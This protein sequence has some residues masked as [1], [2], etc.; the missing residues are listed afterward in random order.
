MSN[1]AHSKHNSQCSSCSSF[2]LRKQNE[3]IAWSNNSNLENQQ[4]KKKPTPKSMWCAN[5]LHTWRRIAF[6]NHQNTNHHTVRL[7]P[8]NAF[9]DD[10]HDLYSIIFDESLIVGETFNSDQ[11]IAKPNEI[12]VFSFFFFFIFSSN[13]HVAF[14]FSCGAIVWLCVLKSIPLSNCPF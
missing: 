8:G 9:V 14:S 12:D 5:G 3:K 2:G 13:S 4:N 11:T 10:A 6:K 7:P 1:V